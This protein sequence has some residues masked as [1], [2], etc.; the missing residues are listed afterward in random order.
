MSKRQDESRVRD[1]A[2]E[3]AYWLHRL[4]HEDSPALRA[5][6]DKWVRQAP[7]HLEEFL[8]A[9][10]MWQELSK[11]DSSFP[12]EPDVAAESVVPFPGSSPRPSASLTPSPRDG[13]G[14]GEAVAETSSSPKREI[15]RRRRWL[16]GLAASLAGVLLGTVLVVRFVWNLGVYATPVGVQ[17]TVKLDDG[18]VI[19][20]N[21]SSRVKVEYSTDRRAVRLF[22]GEALFTVAKD[23]SRPFF[24]L[25]DNAEVRAVGT[26]FSVYRSSSTATSVAVLEGAVEVSVPKKVPASEEVVPKI[27]AAGDEATV[28]R[29][30][31][32]KAVKPNVQRAVA[33]RSRQLIFSG[34]Q[35]AEIVA[36]F[37]RYN[38]RQIRVEGDEIRDRQLSG[39]FDADDPSP[40]VR[41]LERDPQIEV[42]ET[43]D[44]ILIRPRSAN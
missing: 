10:A 4:E 31:V 24:V 29:A 26:Q 39:L 5:E 18:S 36:E 13:D 19:F 14:K 30:Q 17:A 38:R 34:D 11:V 22:E 23:S 1:V 33:W 42:V 27:L 3:A 20:L 15:P 37:N 35:V 41:F 16:F 8:F 28:E 7:I 25:T 21:T 32:L 12:V 2:E 6:F 9:Q 44:A 40:V 43:E